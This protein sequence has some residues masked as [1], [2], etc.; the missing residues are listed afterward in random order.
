MG[1]TLSTIRGLLDDQLDFGTSSAATNP[2]STVLNK[3]INNSIR[4]ITRLDKPR[5][6]YTSSPVKANITLSTNTVA[7]PANMLIPN[8]VYYK[9]TSGTRFEMIQKPL[10][11]IISLVSPNSF[12]NTEN[13]GTPEFYDVQGTDLVFSKH[14]GRTEANAIEILGWKVPS[15]LTNDT[16]VTELPQ[17]YDLLI[18]YESCILFYQKDDDIQNLQNY[19]LL[20]QQERSNLRL[21]LLTNDSQTIQL[22]PY[23][24]TGTGNNTISNPNVFFQG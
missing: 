18:V 3:Y 10:D 2:N 24:F 20:A 7:V 6:L 4:K 17:D 13:T 16:D 5:E 22:D 12:F 1:S 15:T 9:A 19:Q 11:Q 8:A 23:T 21:S 14:F